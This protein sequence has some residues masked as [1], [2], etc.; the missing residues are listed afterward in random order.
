M[1]RTKD[2]SFK[3]FGKPKPPKFW[4]EVVYCDEDRPS[5]FLRLNCS[6]ENVQNTM[7]V[8]LQDTDVDCCVLLKGTADI[9]AVKASD[10]LLAGER[11]I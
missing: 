11:D 1:K 9:K 6:D 3:G 4:V 2:K 8:L 7:D 10:I 5:D